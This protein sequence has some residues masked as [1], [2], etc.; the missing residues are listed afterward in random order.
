MSHATLRALDSVADRIKQHRQADPRGILVVEGDSDRRLLSRVFPERW[1]VFIAGTRDSVPTVIERL[2]ALELRRFAGLVDRDFDSLVSTVEAS[3]LPVFSYQE[4]DLEAALIIGPWFELFLPEYASAEKVTNAGGADSVRQK[5]VNIASVVGAARRANAINSWGVDFDKL[6]F[7]RKL[8][9]KD[10][11]F[12]H[13]SFSQAVVGRVGSKDPDA[14]LAEL[15]AC[16]SAPGARNGFRGK[17]A[18]EVLRKGLKRVYGSRT[19]EHYEDLAGALRLSA[20]SRLEEVSPFPAIF[21]QLS[22]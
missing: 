15:R 9:E 21:R 8:R 17:D 16:A 1:V 22:Q 3:G 12:E 19:I 11:S 10:L 7:S 5:I 6:N 13:E 18:L 14:V 4:A 20:N 2:Q